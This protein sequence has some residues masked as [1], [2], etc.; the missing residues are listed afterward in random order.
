V[1]AIQVAS[2]SPPFDMSPRKFF[3]TFPQE[4]ISE[5]LIS[6]TLGEKFGVV[7]NIRAA[8]IDDAVALVAVEIEGESE[9]IEKA[10]AYLVEKGVTVEEMAADSE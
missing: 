5:P 2:L 9:Q 4:R 6:H 1:I 10:V 3:C 7:P 8:S